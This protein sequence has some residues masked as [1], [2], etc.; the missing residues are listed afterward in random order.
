MLLLLIPAYFWLDILKSWGFRLPNSPNDIFWLKNDNALK[1]GIILVLYELIQKK[2]EIKFWSIEKL[3]KICCCFIRVKWQ[4][5]IIYIFH[6][7]IEKLK[8]H[9][10][11]QSLPV[12]SSL[13]WC[14]LQVKPKKNTTLGFQFFVH[15]FTIFFVCFG[16]DDWRNTLVTMISWGRG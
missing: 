14:F 6:M 16:A 2:K 5:N 7:D 11:N 8:Y 4:I 3:G 1:F 9:Y 13:S 10:S 15:F 12:N